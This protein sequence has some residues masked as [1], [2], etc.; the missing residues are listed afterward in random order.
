LQHVLRNTTY[1]TIIATW[2]WGTFS[3]WCQLACDRVTARI[4]F[5]ALINST[6]VTILTFLNN[7]VP[8]CSSYRQLQQNPILNP[9]FYVFAPTINQ[10]MHIYNFHLKHL[11]PLRHVSIFSET[12]WWW[13]EKIETCRSGFKCFKWKLYRCIFWLIVEVILQNAWSSDEILCFQFYHNTANLWGQIHK[14]EN[15][16][17][18][19]PCFQNY[20]YDSSLNKFVHMRRK[21]LYWLWSNLLLAALKS[22]YHQQD[23]KFL[24]YYVQ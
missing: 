19:C 12:P 2:S 21:D 11:K 13:S 14:L 7:T 4:Q 5:R 18:S 17:P 3:F 6:T 20:I 10:Q 16:C 8:T 23:P 22:F 1:P 15:Y 24:H 9:K